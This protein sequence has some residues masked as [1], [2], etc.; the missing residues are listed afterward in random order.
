MKEL[1]SKALKGRQ[2]TAAFTGAKAA[3]IL[4][5]SMQ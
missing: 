5:H 3:S 2:A 4:A 1:T